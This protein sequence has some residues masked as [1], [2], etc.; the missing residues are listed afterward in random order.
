LGLVVWSLHKQKNN[1]NNEEMILKIVFFETATRNYENL[2][3]NQLI[4]PL[5]RKYNIIFPS[6]IPPPPPSNA[7]CHIFGR[8]ICVKNTSKISGKMEI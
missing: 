8:S 6:R 1:N 3:A 4:R 2:F 5:E 7:Y